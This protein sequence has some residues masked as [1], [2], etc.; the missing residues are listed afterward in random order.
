MVLFNFMSSPEIVL[1]MLDPFKVRNDYRS[2]VF[3]NVR[4]DENILPD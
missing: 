3:E 4:A 1:F 2:R